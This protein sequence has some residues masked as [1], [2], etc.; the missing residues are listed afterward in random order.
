MTQPRDE[1]PEDEEAIAA[2]VTA[3]FLTAPHADGN[4]AGIVGR[5]RA[6]DGL[7]LSLVVEDK[8]QAGGL[9]GHIAA[10]AATIAGRPGWAAIAPVSVAPPVQ[11][12]GIGTALI[13]A[14]LDRQRASGAAGAVLVG[15][16]GY[17][18]R[19][20]F[21]ARDGLTVTGIPDHYVLALPFGPH[22][23]WGDVTFH[24]AFGLG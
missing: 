23:R 16:P 9:A 24:P 12:R 10:S 19:F 20:G 21:Q 11:R 17:Y 4:E 3:A 5:L 6:A 1:T 18:G 13:R 15:D 2:L 8:G 14:A 22:D 7:L